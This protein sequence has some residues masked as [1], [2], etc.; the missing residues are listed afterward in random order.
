MLYGKKTNF[1]Y[2][3]VVGC[4]CVFAVLYTDLY[5]YCRLKCLEFI[6]NE[7]GHSCQSV[8]IIGIALVV[9]MKTK[10]NHHV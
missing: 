10:N 8:F 5:I 9:K 3:I 2:H 4:V 1:E 7:I 6:H